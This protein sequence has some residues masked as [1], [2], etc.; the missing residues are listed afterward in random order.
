M[1]SIGRCD[2]QPAAVQT[3]I[4][5]SMKRSTTMS[6]EPETIMTNEDASSL[7]DKLNAFA[8]GLSLGEATIL[9]ALLERGSR[10]DDNDTSGYFWWF[11]QP[12]NQSGYGLIGQDGAS[13]IGKGGAGFI[14]AGV[15]SFRG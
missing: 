11:F 12:Q 15:G 8:A 6:T 10:K 3:D 14:S 1:K 9:A 2:S 13:L 4:R 5:S 7:R